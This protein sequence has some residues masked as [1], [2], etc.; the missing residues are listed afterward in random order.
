MIWFKKTG[1]DQVASDFQHVN[2]SFK[3]DK[4]LANYKHSLAHCLPHNNY[5]LVKACF[6]IHNALHFLLST[7]GVTR[8][9]PYI[10]KMLCSGVCVCFDFRAA[11]L[12]R[13]WNCRK[14]WQV[15]HRD[16]FWLLLIDT[17]SVNWPWQVIL[18][19]RLKVCKSL[20]P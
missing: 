5:Q 13:K 1:N 12:Q 14:L 7:P 10:S 19:M 11:I 4:F 3:I 18:K 15:T 20:H 8:I 2:I 17:L 9:T 16:F 6:W